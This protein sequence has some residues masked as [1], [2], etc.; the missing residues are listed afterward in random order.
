MMMMMKG[1]LYTKKN[2]FILKEK[3]FFCLLFTKRE[4]GGL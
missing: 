1:A 2:A 4:R 3:A